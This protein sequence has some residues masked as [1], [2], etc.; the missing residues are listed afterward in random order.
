MLNYKI[1]IIGLGYVGLPLALAFG[2]KFN[3]IGFDI[4]KD[5]V[6]ELQDKKDSN[7]LSK[8]KFFY[9][10]KKLQF[11][12]NSKDLKKANIF[13][14]TVPTPVKKN[15]Q[16][17]LSFLYSASKIVA[18]NLKKSDLVIY[19]S[20]VYPG[21]TE[22]ECIPLLEKYSKLEF[23]KD[24]FV[25]YSP[26]RVSPGDR[27]ELKNISKVV[28]GSNSKITDH[29]YNLYKKIIKAKVHKATSIKVAEASKV[30]E[31]AQRDINISF[32]NEISLICCKLGISTSEVLEAANTKWNFINFRPGL[33][34][35]HCIS[36]DPYYL[37]Y[38]AK[39]LGYSPK[40]ILSGRN[41]NNKM[42]YYVASILLKKLKKRKLKLSECR[43][44][45][46]GVTFKENC[47]D[48]RE[49]KVL[50]I[51]KVLQKAKIKLQVYD[52]IVSKKEFNKYYPN[53][54]INKLNKKLD[55]IIIAVS[56]REFLKLNYNQL[57]K[58]LKKEDSIIIDVKS[59][60]ND[61][62]IK[63]NFDY[64]SL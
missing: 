55:A 26:E 41:I 54:K 33:V 40:V 15:K 25:G 21:L 38:K 14:I 30:I 27:R 59:I 60:L 47:N 24:F 18:D 36:V 42:G 9:R 19:E 16:P 3:T 4:K 57:K 56:H 61:K 32:M 12:S 58:M 31:N 64:W 52:P 2:E 62:R 45:I 17:D 23:N 7:L 44:G 22:E 5:R 39:K 34:G 49:S 37:T 53:L 29:V 11:S 63:N 20:T 51:I 46:L 10:S 13:I 6:K 35:G 43:V 50:D 1:A 48:L 8:K 28:S